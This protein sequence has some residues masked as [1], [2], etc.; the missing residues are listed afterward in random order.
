[1]Q[2]MESLHDDEIV[3]VLLADEEEGEERK[4]KDEE[5]QARST[6]RA[7][8]AGDDDERKTFLCLEGE[9]HVVNQE[10]KCTVC[11]KAQVWQWCNSC[12]VY[13]FSKKESDVKVHTRG[14]SHLHFAAN[15]VVFDV[16]CS[17]KCGYVCFSWTDLQMAMQR[18][19]CG[20]VLKIKCPDCP[21][22]FGFKG[23]EVH[24][25]NVHIRRNG[26]SPLQQ[27]HANERSKAD[28]PKRSRE[29]G[30]KANAAKP[31]KKKE[32]KN[33]EKMAEKKDA[34]K[35]KAVTKKAD[36]KVEKPKV[37]PAPAAPV[38]N[39][40]FVDFV[41]SLRSQGTDAAVVSEVLKI[42]KDQILD[43]EFFENVG[44]E[45]FM[46]LEKGQPL[47]VKQLLREIREQNKK[48]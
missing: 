37:S 33:Y 27:R 3:E 26:T 14:L 9:D 20:G 12:Q 5:E 43:R 42:V 40:Q 2:D 39:A 15:P 19:V 21:K 36:K 35:K 1:M 44:D 34:M 48:Q 45:L 7:Q 28:P 29:K 30:A 6:A 32:K 24:F 31:L 25:A 13:F 38:R 47:G 11:E 16:R 8:E 18:C 17:R 22:R 4:E 10:G 41:Q 23:F 46:E